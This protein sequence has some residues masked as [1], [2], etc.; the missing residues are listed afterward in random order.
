[1]YDADSAPY[2]HGTSERVARVLIRHN[3]HFAHKPIRTLWHE[4]CHVKAHD[5]RKQTIENKAGVVYKLGCNLQWLW[6]GL[7]WEVYNIF[8]CKRRWKN[9]FSCNSYHHKIQ[10]V[11]KECIHTFLAYFS[12]SIKNRDVK[13]WHNLL[14]QVFNL[15]YQNSKAISLIVWKLCAFRQRSISGNFQQSFYHN[16]YGFIRKI[17]FSCIRINPILDFKN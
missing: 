5:N 6:C 9:K 14:C 17:L 11:L 3:I 8:Q 4:L 7:Q 2:I 15:C 13:L 16:F 1:M 12:W 10:G